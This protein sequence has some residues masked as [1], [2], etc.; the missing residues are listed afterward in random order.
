[1]PLREAGAAQ[2]RVRAELGALRVL[3]HNGMRL[4]LQRVWPL[5]DRRLALEYRDARGG[6]VAAQWA[7]RA[8]RLD[9]LAERT[10]GGLVVGEN[11]ARVLL[12]PGGADRRLPALAE[13]L[14]EPGARL[15]THRAEQRAVVRTDEALDTT[16]ATVTIARDAGWAAEA[17]TAA[18]RLAADAFAVPVPV[19]SD[20]ERGI[21]AFPGL[22][23]ATLRERLADSA[24][25]RGRSATAAGRAL[26]ALH[27]ARPPSG[28]PLRGAAQEL[29]RLDAGIERL[30]PHAPGLACFIADAAAPAAARLKAFSARA[31]V[32]VHGD[33]HDGQ[34]V[35]D[36]G[37]IGV[38]S[39]DGLGLGDRALDL[40]SLTA[41]LELRAL[42]R[43]C[44][45]AVAAA[46]LRAVCAGYEVGS[47]L[48]AHVAAYADVLRLRLACEHALRPGGAQLAWLL[49]RRV[50]RAEP[51]RRA[52]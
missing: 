48:A 4:R 2:P 6:V 13:L 20:V 25:D 1:M 39:W 51:D 23:G 24:P 33:F 41:H 14:A 44:S 18:Q 36:G 42:E 46:A 12:Q 8:A 3:A 26:R 5:R 49:L 43:R 40:A 29:G 22:P 50:G 9:W 45:P 28:L 35:D 52:R 11:G 17:A 37:A 27:D 19:W 10:P 47:A 31:A 34:V 32:A 15:V 21:V 30:M 16:Y 38:L 7:A